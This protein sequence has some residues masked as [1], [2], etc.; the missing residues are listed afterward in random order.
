MKLKKEVII[1]GESDSNIYYAMCAGQ[2]HA[3][4]RLVKLNETAYF[5]GKCMY[6]EFDEEAVA[7][8]LIGE[9]EVGREE[10][11]ESVRYVIEVFRKA[12][13]LSL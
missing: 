13:F 5:I 9:Y 4:D 3:I 11:L 8:K 7:E 2:S 12:D 1:S 6:E 10:A